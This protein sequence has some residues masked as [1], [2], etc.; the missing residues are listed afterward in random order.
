MLLD[1]C[2]LMDDLLFQPDVVVA[3]FSLP[4]TL[5][6]TIRLALQCSYLYFNPHNIINVDILPDYIRVQRS[7][8]INITAIHRLG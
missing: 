8:H 4:L 7:M 1:C 2:I 5:S 6:S 3:I